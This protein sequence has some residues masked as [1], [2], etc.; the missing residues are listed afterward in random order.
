[1]E[2]MEQGRANHLEP[3]PLQGVRVLA[4]TQAWSGTFATELLA[5]LGA[6]VIQVE[7]RRRPDNF[8]GSYTSQIPKNLRQLPSARRSWNLA[9]NYNSVNLNKYGV[10]L[11]LSTDEGLALF[12]RLVPLSDV[13]AENFSPRVMRNFGLSYDD[14]RELREDIIM[15]SISAYGA[16]GPYSNYPGIGATIEAMSGLASLLGYEGEEPQTSGLMYPDPI[17]GYAGAAAVILALHWR[18]VSGRGQHIDLSMQE[19]CM[20]M[21]GDALIEYALAGTVREPAGNRHPLIAPHGVYPCTDGR[22]VALCAPSDELFG[23]LA[24]CAGHPE[25]ADDPRFQDNARR[26]AHED[27]LNSMLTEWTSDQQAAAVEA[28]LN[29][30]GIPASRVLTANEIASCTCCEARGVVV[31]LLHPEAG[32]H[33]YVV[34][35]WTLD[36]TPRGPYRPAPRLGEHSKEV[37]ARLLA[38]DET[39]YKRLERTGITG[40]G[41]PD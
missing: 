11:D 32:E 24:I 13:V 9:P 34:E 40:E 21:I 37:F 7:S 20:A 28:A 23:R 12:R 36:R 15:L 33:G 8:R 39:E 29:A 17:A 19:A 4:L 10:T 2:R 35:P 22:W 26:K 27:I 1:M 30:A 38:V 25:W 6:E 14:L 18:E 31:R 41:P 3:K 5:W 16:T